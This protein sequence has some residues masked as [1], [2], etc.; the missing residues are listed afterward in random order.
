M[1]CSSKGA[2]ERFLSEYLNLLY[3][4]HSLEVRGIPL[5]RFSDAET[6]VEDRGTDGGSDNDA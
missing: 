1:S 3:N 4:V 6:R 5:L 2:G